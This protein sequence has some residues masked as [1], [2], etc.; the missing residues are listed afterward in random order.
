MKKILALVLAFGLMTAILPAAAEDGGNLLTLFGVSGGEGDAQGVV[1]TVPDGGS[2]LNPDSLGS[3]FGGTD[4]GEKIYSE[5]GKDELPGPGN[6]AGES[7]N[8]GD[9]EIYAGNGADILAGLGNMAGGTGNTEYGEICSG[10]GEDVIAGSGNIIGDEQDAIAGLRN[11]IGGAGDVLGESGSMH[12]GSSTGF[13]LGSLGSMF[14]GDGSGIDLGGLGGLFGGDGSGPDL[15]GLGSLFGGDGSGIDLGSLGNLFGGDGSGIDLGGLGSL[16][17]GDGSGID[18]SG[19]GSLFGGDGSGID[20]GS[21]LGSGKNTPVNTVP[22]ESPDQFYG[23]WEITGLRAAGIEIGMDKLKQ[24][25]L[26]DTSSLKATL[27][28]DSVSFSETNGRTETRAIT[29]S[30]FSDGALTIT[31]E[32]TPARLQLTDTGNLLCTVSG[33]Q[34]GMNVSLDIILS[35]VQ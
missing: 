35:R 33:E 11:I 31:V 5:D 13:D 7:R 10:D 1:G 3:M 9:R 17:G 25:G 19:L 28:A 16:F 14:S 32:S 22:A 20:L 12:S 23:I 34:Y 2:E 18:L 6:M 24:F 27:T 26:E 21:L 29:A 30:E 4:E 8:A 15:G